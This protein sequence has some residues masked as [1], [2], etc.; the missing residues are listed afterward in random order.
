MYGRKK[1]RIFGEVVT[2]FLGGFLDIAF[3]DEHIDTVPGYRTF[4]CLLDY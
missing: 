1:F 2:T 4:K 3:T